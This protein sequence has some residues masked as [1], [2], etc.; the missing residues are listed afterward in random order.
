L[1]GLVIKA[2][3]VLALGAQPAMYRAQTVRPPDHVGDVVR[4][5]PGRM[6]DVANNRGIA[7]HPHMAAYTYA[8]NRDMGRLW[9]HVEG[10]AGAA[11]FL[12]IDLP[13][14]GKDKANL[15]KRGVV[16]ELDHA[17]GFLICGP[18]WTGRARDCE[19]RVWILPR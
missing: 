10:P 2:A 17:S 7:H 14:P 4:Y 15:I 16:A 13:R 8:R 18:R 3:L 9:L 6:D 1:T 5:A 11:D 12:V 19:V